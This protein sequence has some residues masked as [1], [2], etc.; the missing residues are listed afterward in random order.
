MAGVG[1]LVRIKGRKNAVNYRSGHNL[2]LEEGYYP[3]LTAKTVKGQLCDCVGVD[4]PKPRLEPQRT[5]MERPEDGG[6]QM[7]AIQFV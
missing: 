4:Q 5:S 7:H 1:R 3:N 2:S 6:L